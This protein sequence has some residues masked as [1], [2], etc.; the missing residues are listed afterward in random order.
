[1]PEFIRYYLA[2]EPILPNVETWRCLEP[3]HLSHVLANLDSLVCK[4]ANEAGGKGVTIGS[5]ASQAELEDLR[6]QI[7]ADPRNWVA[8]PI[9]KLSTGP[10]ICGET[11]AP[12]H[13]DLRPFILS[14]DNPYVT[15]GG[16]TRVALREGSLIVNSSQGGGSKDTWI[17]D[18][19]T[20]PQTRA[21]ISTA[22]PTPNHDPKS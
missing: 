1:V 18:S 22:T 14:G 21:Q 13:L 15:L 10:T 12:R 20:R 11:V 8:Q 4:P 3:S 16:L 17:V 7:V 6:R 5:M 9:L 19:K 2:E